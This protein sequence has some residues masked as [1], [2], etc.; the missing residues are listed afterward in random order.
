M[1]PKVLLQLGTFIYDRCI[2]EENWARF[3]Q[4][5]E[6][7][8]RGRTEPMDEDELRGVLEGVTG[9]MSFGR[10]LP[11]LSRDI[12]KEADSLK[13]IGVW[14]DRFGEE[15]D[16]EAALDLDI[17][18]VDVDNITCAQPVAE[19]VLGLILAC[20]RNAGEI[21]RRMIDG[22]ETW[23]DTLNDGFVNGELTGR[24]VGLVGCGH[25]GQRFIELLDPF[26]VNLKVYDPFLP[27]E[28][29]EGLK[30]QRGELDDV[31]QHSEILVLQVPHTPTTEGMIGRSELDLLRKG[32]VLIN[33]CRGKVV[34]SEAL[35]EKLEKK[36]IIAG[37]DVFD[38]EPLPKDDPLRTFP[39]AILSPHIAW[40]A[41][42]SFPRCFDMMLDEFER[43]FQG[44]PL[45]YELT[46]RLVELRNR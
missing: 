37:L 34:D 11:Y 33:C 46:A 13:I 8:G 20:L 15:L 43:F 18:V 4:L 38:P 25:V 2:T 24:S 39:N 26:R 30:I 9:L 29:V 41:Q 21:Y 14:G 5:A 28:T 23:L 31:I 6:P 3:E 44:R 40:C 10:L 1:R 35:I 36:E 42:N 16:L 22:T 32:A 12:L 19:W 45:E 17:K 27:D 7:V